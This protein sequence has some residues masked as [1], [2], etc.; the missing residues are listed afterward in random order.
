MTSENIR[1]FIKDIDTISV[2]IA[3]SEGKE[4][5]L[6]HPALKYLYSGKLSY[7]DKDCQYFIYP[8]KIFNELIMEEKI[9][10]VVKQMPDLFGTNKTEDVLRGL[11]KMLATNLPFEVY[12]EMISKEQFAFI[13]EWSDNKLIR[14]KILR[15]DLYRL[16]HNYVFTGGLFHAFRHFNLQG[17]ALT[18]CMG[19]YKL[20]WIRHFIVAL[21][22]AFLCQDLD[23]DPEDTNRYISKIQQECHTFKFVFYYNK[24]AKVYF[25]DTAH[26]N[27]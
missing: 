8:C 15:L 6:G 18:T 10:D 21:L 25:L 3:T 27:D 24:E 26:I 4:H 20:S 17:Y 23:K 2:D 7:K 12:A 1:Q 5:Y 19:E 13:G 16:N 22:K 9:M 11:H 14:E